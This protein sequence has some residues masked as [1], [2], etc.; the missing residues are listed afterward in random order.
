MASSNWFWHF[1]HQ[2]AHI[3]QYTSTIK[4]VER[5]RNNQL[6]I[7]SRRFRHVPSLQCRPQVRRMYQE[8]RI[9]RN[10]HDQAANLTQHCA[11]FVLFY[12]F[13]FILAFLSHNSKIKHEMFRFDSVFKIIFLL[14][15]RTACTVC[16]AWHKPDHTTVLWSY[17]L[18]MWLVAYAR[19]GIPSQVWI[20]TNSLILTKNIFFFFSFSYVG[21][22]NLK[23]LTFAIIQQ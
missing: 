13:H 19:T 23:Q 12:Y 9:C 21:I 20:T 2:S 16:H 1:M 15:G 6:F 7:S 5:R 11:F 22:I 17:E 8:M 4:T 3:L 18:R 10:D 14:L